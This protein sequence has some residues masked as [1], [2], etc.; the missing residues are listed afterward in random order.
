[1]PEIRMIQ[2]LSGRRPDG[3]LWPPVGG[4]LEVDADEA[5]ALTHTQQQQSHPIAVLVSE[6]KEERAVADETVTE[7][8]DPVPVKT[9]RAARPEPRPARPATAEKR[10]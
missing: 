4:T 2:Q 9:A 7:T 8:A 10:G 3:R 6:V 1:M 5:A